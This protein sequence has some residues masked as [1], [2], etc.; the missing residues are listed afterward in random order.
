MDPA[1]RTLARPLRVSP[2]HPSL[3][4]H[5]PGRPVV[6]GVVLLDLVLEA[7]G[8]LL[9]QAP[10]V[11]QL[12]QAKFLAPLLPGEDARVELAVTG[13]ALDFRIVRGDALLAQGRFVLR[14]GVA[15]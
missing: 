6:P 9:G 4:G 12:A 15:A 2:E 8:E 11:A 13:T 10:E 5:F 3:P 1:Q 14:A 7:A